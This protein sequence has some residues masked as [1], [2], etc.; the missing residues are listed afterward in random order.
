MKILVSLSAKSEV[1]LATT[2]AAVKKYFK[3]FKHFDS[4]HWAIL[5]NC[6]MLCNGFRGHPSLKKS[7]DLMVEITDQVRDTSASNITPD[8]SNVDPKFLKL[9]QTAFKKLKE[10]VAQTKLTGSEAETWETAKNL[11]I[12]CKRLLDNVDPVSDLSKYKGVTDAL[13][14]AGIKV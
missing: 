2:D 12:A 4:D 13:K 6:T 1:T 7:Y 11:A 10:I 8:Y 9:G 3:K 5:N 14:M